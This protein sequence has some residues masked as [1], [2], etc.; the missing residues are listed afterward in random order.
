MDRSK[1]KSLQHVNSNFPLF[2]LE[3]PKP[4]LGGDKTSDLI[5]TWELTK[6]N[7]YLNKHLELP[8]PKG[9]TKLR[10]VGIYGFENAW[11]LPCLKGHLS[12]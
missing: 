9:P 1:Y 12:Y 2:L 6:G 7:F 8:P 10:F 4:P 3:V 11:G 5:G